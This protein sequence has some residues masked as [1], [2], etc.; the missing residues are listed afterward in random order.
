MERYTMKDVEARVENVNN[1]LELR[2]SVYRISVGQSN[3]YTQLYEVKAD[4]KSYNNHITS[5]TKKEIAHYLS[6]MM[7]GMDLIRWSDPTK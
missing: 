4:D 7:R 5:G 6:A 1:R 3:G 2:K